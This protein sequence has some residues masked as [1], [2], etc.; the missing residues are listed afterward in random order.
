MGCAS[1]V[2]VGRIPPLAI[3]AR[4]DVRLGGAALGA[5]TWFMIGF[6]VVLVGVFIIMAAGIYYAYR[7]ASQSKAEVG[8]VVMIGPIPIV[9]GTSWKMAI[10]AMALAVVL[11]VIALAL[12]LAVGRTMS[13][14][15]AP[16]GAAL[17]L[18]P[19]SFRLS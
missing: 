11:M 1:G 2:P 3:K 5:L 17:A 9:F 18:L 4:K 13:A 12:M 7:Q 10:I 19:P 15:T 14:P 8:G 6:L 16:A